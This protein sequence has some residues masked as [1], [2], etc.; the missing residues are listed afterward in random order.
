MSKE[1]KQK[2]KSDESN[3]IDESNLSIITKIGY[4]CGHVLNDLFATVWFSYTLLFLKYVLLMPIE[5]GSFMM[6]GQLTDAFFSAIV[7]FLTDLYGTKRNWHFIGSIIVCLSFPMIFVMQRDVLPYWAKIFYFSAVIALFQC[8]W[9]TVQISHLAIIPEYSNSEK[10]RSE[11]NAVRFS[12]S[13]LSNITVFVIAF[14][15]LHIRDKHA[16]EIGPADFEKFRNITLLLTLIGIVTTILFY[17]SLSYGKYSDRIKEKNAL[18]LN[19]VED[20]SGKKTSMRIMNVLT[21]IELYKVAFVYTFSRLFLLICI[22]YI[23]IWLNELMKLKTGQTIEN[24]AII[25]LTFFASSF[26]VAVLLKFINQN[27]S[28]NI[29]YS[30]GSLISIFGCIIIAVPINIKVIELVGIAILL[31]AG[32]SITQISS[33]CIASNFIGSK[34]ENGGLVYSIVTVCDKIFSGIIIFIIEIIGKKSDYYTG[35]LAINGIMP[36]LGILVLFSIKK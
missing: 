3:N 27:I 17:I 29:I 15:F 25:P 30:I 9:A 28:Q 13:I 21:N 1:N 20:P 22:I 5:A 31:G 18:A 24:I 26:V 34:C 36:V 6:L 7:G 10:E 33:M 12:M 2:L 11:L 4:G 8:G 14:V 23:P 19:S 35:V 16:D 32:S